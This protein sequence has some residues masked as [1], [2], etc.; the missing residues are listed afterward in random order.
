MP[1][2]FSVTAAPALAASLPLAAGREGPESEPTDPSPPTAAVHAARGRAAD[3]REQAVLA[4]MEGYKQV[5]LDSDTAALAR[6]WT[7]NYTFINPQ[8]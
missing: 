4:A 7:Q 8:A 2:R 3:P 5:I 6:T 1:T